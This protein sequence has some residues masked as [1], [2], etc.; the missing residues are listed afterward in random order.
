MA[1][2]ALAESGKRDAIPAI[3]AAFSYEKAP[4]TR[5]L[6][7]YALAVLG[8][9]QG[10]AD[11]KGMCK[12]VGASATFRWSAAQYLRKLHDD[13]WIGGLIAV[14]QSEKQA[15]LLLERG[16][17]NLLDVG[18]LDLVT[19]LPPDKASRSQLDEIRGLAADSLSAVSP[20]L[21][22]AA[23]QALAAFGDSAS[24][25]R[26]DAAIAR[27]K[28]QEVLSHMKGDLEKLRLSAH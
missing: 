4:G 13:S 11:L 7:A 6:M 16:R 23:S 9:K 5:M 26:L 22:I 20:D 27:E 3:A 10:L 15:S 12:S 17:N 1:A 28:D 2:Q 8:D 19:A 24:A 18:L 21:R 14:L 25:T